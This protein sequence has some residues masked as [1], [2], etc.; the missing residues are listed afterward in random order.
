[1]SGLD[2]VRKGPLETVR[3]SAALPAAGAWDDA[4][5][6]TELR[7]H[8]FSQVTVFADYTEGTSGGA[9]EYVV[10]TSP[11]SSGDDWFPAEEV[12][13]ETAVAS[14]GESRIFP[15][16][17]ASMRLNGTQRAPAHTLDVSGADRLRVRAREVGVTGTPGTFR[18]RARAVALGA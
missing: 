16:R 3:A 15:V 9:V 2:M 8:E 6:V 14:S 10:E 13:D 5:D 4:A 7:V 1:M 18:V 17:A 11:V 12:I